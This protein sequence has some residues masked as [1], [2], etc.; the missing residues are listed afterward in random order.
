MGQMTA[1]STVLIDAVP[2]TV[3]TAAADYQAVRPK[4]LSPHYSDYRTRKWRSG[5]RHRAM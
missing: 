4:I 2:E 5:C 1:S 3:L